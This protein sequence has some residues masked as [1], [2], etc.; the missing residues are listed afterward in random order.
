ML[1]CVF[2]FSANCRLYQIN[3]IGCEDCWEQQ[4]TN[5]F[6]SIYSCLVSSINLYQ[7]QIAL[8]TA[9]TKDNYSLKMNIVKK[10]RFFPKSSEKHYNK[11]VWFISQEN[12][13]LYRYGIKNI[14]VIRMNVPILHPWV[15]FPFFWYYFVT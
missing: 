9:Y 10:I 15:C 7:R 6:Y 2:G 5:V 1:Q 3:C 4:E 8:L 13:F 14:L 11:C 12:L